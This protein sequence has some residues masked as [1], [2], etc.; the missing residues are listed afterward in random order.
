M[1]IIKEEHVQVK[2]GKIPSDELQVIA[3]IEK[4]EKAKKKLLKDLAKRWAGRRIN[5][6]DLIWSI[7]SPT[8]TR[9]HWIAQTWDT[10][11]QRQ[12]LVHLG[13]EPWNAEEK[14]DRFFARKE[15]NLEL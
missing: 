8:E 14:I 4:I 15:R 3:T 13:Q 12:F 9:K 5:H 6:K 7:L 2:L 11:I 10:R 1:K